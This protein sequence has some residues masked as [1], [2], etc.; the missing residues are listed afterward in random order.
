MT[1][2]QIKTTTAALI[3]FTSLFFGS[4]YFKTNQE[5]LPVSDAYRIDELYDNRI[6]GVMIEFEGMVIKKLSDDNDGSRHQRF[7]VELNNGH[8]LLIAHNIDLAPR[9][10]IKLN[11]K[12]T[13]FG[14]YEWNEKGG[15]I[16]WT[17]KDPAGTHEE[18]WIK[19]QGE[20]Y[21]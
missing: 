10:P 21:H 17:H 2:K 14:Q 20:T 8:T 9:V 6:S 19:Y 13:I 5:V 16:H 7:I 11:K 15:V 12:V 4:K 3:A 18:G 1:N